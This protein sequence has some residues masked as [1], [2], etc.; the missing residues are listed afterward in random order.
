M[1]RYRLFVFPVLLGVMLTL[2]S[3]RLSAPSALAGTYGSG[4]L[5]MQNCSQVAGSVAICTDTFGQTFSAGT[6]IS[7]SFQGG[8]PGVTV[9]CNTPTGVTCT[10]NGGNTGATLVCQ[11]TCQSGS[12]FVVVLPGGANQYFTL[13]GGAP[14]VTSAYAA[15]TAAYPTT[16]VSTVNPTT[17]GAVTVGQSTPAVNVTVSTN[18]S[19]CG[20]YTVVVT[21]SC[22]SYGSSYGGYGGQCVG[23]SIPT[24]LGCTGPSVI[25]YTYSSPLY[26][27]GSYGSYG[28]GSGYNNCGYGWISTCG[29]N[30][31]SSCS[32]FTFNCGFLGS[33]FNSFNN[34]G[35]FNM[36]WGCGGFN[37]GFG[38]FGNFFGRNFNNNN[39]AFN[40]IVCPAG[41]TLHRFMPNAVGSLCY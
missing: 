33:S 18:G 28:Y 37:N 27:Y 32:V 25:P 23:G 1:H 12:S 35:C 20:G 40:N 5:V 26:G 6:S 31:Y 41:T 11:V 9:T 36:S 39:N 10:V 13:A 34:N 17:V 4:G 3:F 24:Y 22:P 14:A 2:A 38:G 30:S 16:T 21:I 15:P 19:G 29:Y 8:A 7:I